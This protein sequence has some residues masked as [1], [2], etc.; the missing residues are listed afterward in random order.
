MF[1]VDL[2]IRMFHVDILM[3][4]RTSRSNV[5]VREMTIKFEEI[6]EKKSVLIRMSHFIDNDMS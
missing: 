3:I 2:L 1:H 6:C 4:V 5:E